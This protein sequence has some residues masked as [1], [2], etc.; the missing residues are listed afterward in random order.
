MQGS[1]SSAG[2]A[3]S[4]PRHPPLLGQHPL[5]RS[6][7]ERGEEG[8][9]EDRDQQPPPHFALLLHARR[10]PT[11]HLGWGRRRVQRCPSPLLCVGTR[12]GAVCPCHRLPRSRARQ[13]ALRRGCQHPPQRPRT[14][15]LPDATSAGLGG[16]PLPGGEDIEPRGTSPVPPYPCGTHG[17]CAVAGRWVARDPPR[18][19]LPWWEPAAGAEPA[20]PRHHA[21]ISGGQEG[22]VGPPPGV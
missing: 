20:G 9:E 4:S 1:S 10:S 6:V 15:A 16:L 2:S 3:P 18:P 11:L 21:E 13:P 17:T 12:A 8:G 22:E 19:P 7:P 5:H 14:P